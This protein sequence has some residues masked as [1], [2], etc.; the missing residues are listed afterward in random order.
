MFQ[1]RDGMFETNSSSLHA[2]I[3][4]A[5]DVVSH[6]LG[7][8]ELFIGECFAILGSF[9]SAYHR[10]Y[11]FSSKLSY[12]LTVL[13]CD[14][15]SISSSDEID[16][17]MIA[18]WISNSINAKAVID[19]VYQTVGCKVKI[20]AP[21][22]FGVEY[23]Y[24]A[25]NV[26][27]LISK[28][29][30]LKMFLFSSNSY[31]ETGHD[32]MSPPQFIGTD[33]NAIELYIPDLFTSM[34]PVDGKKITIVTNDLCDIGED[35]T[36]CFDENEQRLEIPTSFVITDIHQTIKWSQYRPSTYTRDQVISLVRFAYNDVFISAKL[37]TNFAFDYSFEKIE[38]D[39]ATRTSEFVFT[40]MV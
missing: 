23:D 18:D 17:Y 4:K 12:L 35:K 16:D 24:G 36:E 29:S 21:R 6:D 3:I 5:S 31:V 27:E 28:P 11:N 26:R 13:C 2:L 22:E 39:V 38:S 9:G 14:E 20:I 32:G 8:D 30:D 34:V 1:V 37:H 15:M 25:F 40:C 19:L 33:K 10:Y 7:A